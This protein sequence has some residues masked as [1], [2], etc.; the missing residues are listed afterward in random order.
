MKAERDTIDAH[1]LQEETKTERLYCTFILEVPSVTDVFAEY[2]VH[3][4]F[5]T[6][7]ID[8]ALKE[9][10]LSRIT[11]DTHGEIKFLINW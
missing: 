5:K 2:D 10:F 8:A 7:K 9:E 3:H 6:H 11:I 1:Y 4:T